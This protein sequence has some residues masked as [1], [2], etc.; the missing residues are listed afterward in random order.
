ML[1]TSRVLPDPAPLSNRKQ[2]FSSSVTDTE[3]KKRGSLG[4]S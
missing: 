4:F 1:L 3:W 2:Y